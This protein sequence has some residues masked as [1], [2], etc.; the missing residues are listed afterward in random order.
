MNRDSASNQLINYK[1]NASKPVPISMDSG[2]RVGIE[3]ATL[4]VGPRGPLLMED[5]HF[6]EET[7]RFGHERIPERV[8]FAK[9]A[10]AFGYFEVQNDI[11]KYC[12][13]SLFN[14]EKKRTPVAVRFSS[15]SAEEGSNELSRDPRGF[16]IKF[17]TETG[18]WDLVA[19][20]M[21]VFYVRDP[22]L[23][24]SLAH[25]QKRNPQTHLKDRDMYWDFISQRPE[26]THQMCLNFTD[27]GI[28]D[29]YRHMHGYS[30]HA[31]KLLNA[32][33]E[34]IYAKFHLRTDQGI[35]NL[36]EGRAMCIASRDPDFATR[37][38]YNAICN[39]N[40]PTWT[41][42]MQVMT[43]KQAKN[44]T[45]DPFDPTK[46]WPYKDFPLILIGKLV[47]DRNPNNYFAEIEQLAFNPGNMI[48]GIEPS[49]D[50]VLQGRLFAYAD[51][52]RHRLGPNYSQ[53]P[54]N[55]PFRIPIANYLRDGHM[56]VTDNQ[57]GAPNYYPNFFAGPE[58]C[59]RARNVCSCCPA[60]GD[61]YR[62]PTGET[63]DN[64]SQVTDFW[65]NVLDEC[66]RK[67][68]VLNIAQHLHGASE[69]IQERIVRNL[70]LVHA[71]FGRMLTDRLNVLNQDNC[72]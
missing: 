43:Y 49:S 57:G 42:Y 55:C 67:R 25:S 48:N 69:V 51:A 33:S 34:G 41:M 16:A 61:M 40:H 20:N 11:T 32:K 62:F 3:D 50:K 24:P 9:G 8:V 70:T 4:S 18:V 60:S 26:T 45:F 17:Y 54:V 7:Q 68:L 13:A 28:P 63:E 37:D 47:L 10:G 66:S 22:I 15:F 38:L 29:G 71:D 14:A 12:G 27:R 58:L 23:F 59:P 65:V 64:Y 44:Q 46:V 53:I 6:I 56:T 31:F 52:Q 2:S 19:Q 72:M 5:T 30:V 36:E 21:P 39:N 35:Q 1:N